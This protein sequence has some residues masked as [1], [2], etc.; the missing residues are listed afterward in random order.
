MGTRHLTIVQLG[1][2]YKVAQ[3]GQWDGYPSGAGA[4]ILYFLGRADMAKFRERVGLLTF[5]SE[6]AIRAVFDEIGGPGC[7]HLTSEQSERLYASH[8][9][10]SRDTGSGILDL[11]MDRDGLLMQDMISFAGDS[12][13]CEY[14]YVI[15]LDNDVLELFVGFSEQP[16][17][18]GERFAYL[19]AKD[20]GD[21]GKYWPV[22]MVGRWPLDALPSV[23]DMEAV[24]D[25]DE[26]EEA[27]ENEP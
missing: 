10:L 9:E 11:I 27:D 7:T 21:I 12:L 22:R 3:Y 20:H 8:P 23:A 5:A 1:G 18:K 2:E 25:P 15:D 26:D 13:F 24:A 6:E 14:A 4:D 16:L 19:P 17:D